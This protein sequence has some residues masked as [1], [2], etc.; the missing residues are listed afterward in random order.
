MYLCGANLTTDEVRNAHDRH[1]YLVGEH[2]ER[3]NPYD[4]GSVLGNFHNRIFPTRTDDGT[5]RPGR[6]NEYANELS[7]ATEEQ[8]LLAP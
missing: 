4:T 6:P 5:D 1:H 2:G 7:E 3:I 8:T